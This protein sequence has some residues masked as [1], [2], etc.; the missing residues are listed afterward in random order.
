MAKPATGN[1]E[2]D[3]RVMLKV[4]HERDCDCVVAGFR[5]HKDARGHRDWLTAAWVVTT[6]PVRCSTSGCA[7]ASRWRSAVSWWNFW[8]PTAKMR[9]KD[10][11][12]KSWAEQEAGAEA[13][14]MPG[15]Q[16]RW[17][18]GKD[19][20]WEP[21]RPELVIEV[22]YEHMQGD[23]FRHMAQFRRWR[24]GQNRLPTARMP[25]WKW[26]LRRSSWRFFPRPGSEQHQRPR[27]S[28]GFATPCTGWIVV[29]V[30][31]LLRRAL[32]LWNMANVY[33]DPRPG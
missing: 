18:A 4:K 33:A 15:G 29:W 28:G 9:L 24:Y 17:S 3:K 25:S 23:R 14:S 32:L 13:Q 12:W 27:G 30:R 7:P 31:R 20:S 1:Y 26:C 11:P 21:L 19:L 2:P 8:R 22:A 6:T 5:W 10:H 16:S